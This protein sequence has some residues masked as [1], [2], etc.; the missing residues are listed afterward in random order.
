MNH[1]SR[2][3]TP[4]YDA[5]KQEAADLAQ[6]EAEQQV[7]AADAAR[8]RAE[9]EVARKEQVRLAREQRARCEQAAH[10]VEVATQQLT[11]ALSRYV[12]NAPV[13]DMKG[14]IQNFLGSK[15]SEFV[16]IAVGGPNTDLLRDL[17]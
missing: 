5:V 13:R 3:N 16:H 12:A 10:D 6:W 8:E 11:D 2:P 17:W 14:R 9:L 1:K 7:R 15:L 4:L